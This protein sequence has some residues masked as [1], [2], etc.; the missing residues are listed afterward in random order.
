MEGDEDVTL[1]GMQTHV[2]RRQKSQ[3][4]RFSGWNLVYVVEE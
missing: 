4:S 1:T 2:E 3:A